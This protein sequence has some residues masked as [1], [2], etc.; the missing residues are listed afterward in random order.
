MVNDKAKFC[1]SLPWWRGDIGWLDTVG[2][3]PVREGVLARIELCTHGV[4]HEYPGFL[5]K[6]VGRK[7]MLDSK[8]F[9]F[10]D[11][12]DPK[13][14]EDG[15]PDYPEGKNACYK[16]ISYCGWKWYVAVPKDVRPFCEAV[17]AYVEAFK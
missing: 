2:L 8:Y 15:R 17:R 5:V 13:E 6:I 7:G 4:Q 12:I 1:A 3:L 10:D 11:F 9:L 14:R 16:V